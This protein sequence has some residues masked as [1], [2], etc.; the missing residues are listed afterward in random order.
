MTP[1]TALQTQNSDH[2]LVANLQTISLEK[3][4][5][6]KL[7]VLFQ[8]QDTKYEAAFGMHTKAFVFKQKNA[9]ICLNTGVYYRNNDA[10]YA[11]LGMDY[12]AWQVNL[13]YDINISRFQPASSTY[14]ALEISVI[15]IMAWVKNVNSKGSDCSVL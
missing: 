9:Q 14:G 5:R 12:N 1:E 3:L 6:S 4:V 15:Y 11:L 10:V 2:L 7:E 13:S 8:Q